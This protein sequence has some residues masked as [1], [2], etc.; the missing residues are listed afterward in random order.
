MVEL[1]SLKK[2]N[3]KYIVLNKLELLLFILL[4]FSRLLDNYNRIILY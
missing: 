4:G 2:L 1:T 3:D